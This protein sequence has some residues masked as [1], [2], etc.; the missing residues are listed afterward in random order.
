MPLSP[1]ADENAP[2]S[3]ASGTPSSSAPSSP[4]GSGR[5]S[6]P[7]QRESFILG[8]LHWSRSSDSRLLATA[9]GHGRRASLGTTATSPSTRRRSLDLTMAKIQEA[10]E[11]RDDRAD[12]EEMAEKLS[13]PT[14]KRVSL[15]YSA[16]LAS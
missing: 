3:P 7:W 6:S 15:S 14:R 10:L 4:I 1:Q 12:V 13:S 2:A 16:M 8:Q 11:G 9:A 5:S